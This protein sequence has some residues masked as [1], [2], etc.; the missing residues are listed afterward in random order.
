M[1]RTRHGRSFTVSEAASAV[2][3]ER[4]TDGY[5]AA[6]DRII[7]RYAEVTRQHRPDLTEAEWTVIQHAIGNRSMDDI[8]SIRSLG[9]LIADA[10]GAAGLEGGPLAGLAGLIG[11]MNLATKVA[12][13]DEIE[14]RRAGE[15]NRGPT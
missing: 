12:I 1:A 4:A 2:V 11:N 7:R 5:S 3:N 15:T 13:V 8:L 6:L 14:R 9:L 10:V